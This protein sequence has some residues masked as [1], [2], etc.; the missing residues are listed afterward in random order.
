MFGALREHGVLLYGVWM[1]G[2]QPTVVRENPR[3]IRTMVSP[4][5]GSARPKEIQ[6]RPSVVIVAVGDLSG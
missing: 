6:L 2:G 5:D 3:V 1:Y 4:A